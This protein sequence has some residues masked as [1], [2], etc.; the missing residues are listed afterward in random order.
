M[1]I[2]SC[3]MRRGLMESI[4]FLIQFTQ[5]ILSTCMRIKLITLLISKVQVMVKEFSLKLF[6][7][8]QLLAKEILIKYYFTK[9]RVF[10]GDIFR[11]VRL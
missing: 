4:G 6:K 2:I 10:I 1:E 8:T 9:N 5:D 3:F 11:F 7:K